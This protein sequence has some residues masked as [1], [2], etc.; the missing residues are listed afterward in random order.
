MKKFVLSLLMSIMASSFIFAT[1]ID[2]LLFSLMKD[3]VRLYGKQTYLLEE[4]YKSED[5]V[6]KISATL[7]ETMGLDAKGFV[8]DRILEDDENFL[9]VYNRVA[10]K[11]ENKSDN[12]III[13]QSRGNLFLILFSK[14]KCCIDAVLFF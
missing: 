2:D 6:K 8:F 1:E 3:E 7:V 12:Y 14:E 4:F 11:V 13:E 9:V 10:E 5:F